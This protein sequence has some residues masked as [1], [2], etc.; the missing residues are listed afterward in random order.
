[1]NNIKTLNV[2]S[3]I[4]RVEYCKIEANMVVLD[5]DDETFYV[6]LNCEDFEKVYNGK[7]K[8]LGVQGKMVKGVVVADKCIFI[9]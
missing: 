9:D 4:G 7:K 8:V 2:I 5:V 1:M 3:L 6:A